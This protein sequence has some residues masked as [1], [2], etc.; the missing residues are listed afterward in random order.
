M[1]Y[2]SFIF[3]GDTHGAIDDFKKQKEVITNSDPEFVLVESLQNTVL[4]TEEKYE[5]F[6]HNTQP[7]QLVELCQEKGIKL[8]GID[9]KD[10]GFTA[11]LQKVIEGKIKST[12]KDRA[13]IDAIVKKRQKHHLH[14]INTYKKA[15]I[16]GI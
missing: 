2:F 16:R 9:F 4:D 14:M 3:I 6:K 12:P 11:H 1:K 7:N 5:L 8:I 15:S 13:K 10:F